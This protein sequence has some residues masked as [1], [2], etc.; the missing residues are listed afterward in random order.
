VEGEELILTF[1]IPWVALCSDNRKFKYRYILSDQ[2]REA[3]VLIGAI[4][5]AAAKKNNWAIPTCD[6]G[7]HVV[8]REPDKRRRDLNFSKCAK[9]GITHGAGVWVDDSQVREEHWKFI[10]S[11]KASA[12]ATL[13]IWRLDDMDFLGHDCDCCGGDRTWRVLGQD[14]K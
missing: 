13:T 9:D 3:K 2:Y 5:K 10:R 11:D 1:I 7:L 4:A 12:G 6:V 8:V 14:N